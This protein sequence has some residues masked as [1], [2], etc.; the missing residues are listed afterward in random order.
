MIFLDDHA[1]VLD[2]LKLDNDVKVIQLWH[3][4]AG[5]NLQ[6]IVDGDIK[7]VQAH[8]VVTGS[9]LME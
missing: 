8:R 7:D 4:G 6:D 9:I 1:P 3:A 2:W 5:F